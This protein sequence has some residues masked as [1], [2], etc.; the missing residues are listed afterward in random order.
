MG[1]CRLKVDTSSKHSSPS[2]QAATV[3]PPGLPDALVGAP[4]YVGGQRPVSQL[5]AV[6]QTGAVKMRD[7][8]CLRLLRGAGGAASNATIGTCGG[9]ETEWVLRQASGPAPSPS[10]PSPSPPSPPSL[11]NFTAVAHRIG[12]QPPYA[13]HH[14]KAPTGAPCQAEVGA[15][16]LTD[17]RCAGFAICPTWSQPEAAQR[18]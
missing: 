12:A 7:G 13:Q 8:R 3:L 9:A 6:G 5:F 10:P 4:C 15:A 16:C 1:V 11:R 18:R 14:C 2:H 17:A